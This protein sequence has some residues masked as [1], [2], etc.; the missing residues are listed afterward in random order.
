[1]IC[2]DQFFHIFK[3]K[4]QPVFRSQNDIEWPLL[5][6][7]FS[8]ETWHSQRLQVSCRSWAGSIHWAT[9]GLGFPNGFNQAL[10]FQSHIKME[11]CSWKFIWKWVI[12]WEYH[13]S[14][15]SGGF[16][17]EPWSWL[18]EGIEHPIP[19]LQLKLGDSIIL[20]SRRLYVK[21]LRCRGREREGE[22]DVLYNDKC[23][24]K[25]GFQLLSLQDG[26]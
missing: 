7:R 1:M 19:H 14:M 16:S 22:S 13:R 12:S 25:H 26:F 24:D 9:D 21:S 10:G 3:K 4:T 11:V 20:K 15:I 8:E 18:P 17:S 2:I 6:S 5:P 23:S